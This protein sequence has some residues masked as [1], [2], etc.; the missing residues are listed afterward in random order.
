[1]PHVAIFRLLLSALVQYEQI[2]VVLGLVRIFQLKYDIPIS[3]DKPRALYICARVGR[4]ISRLIGGLLL[5]AITGEFGLDSHF[6]NALDHG[7][8]ASCE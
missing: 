6:L 2:L 1:M 5:D 3:L 4:F 7:V 8:I